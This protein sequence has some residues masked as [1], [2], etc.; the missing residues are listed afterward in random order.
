MDP[1]AGLGKLGNM[2]LWFLVLDIDCHLQCSI[3]A[4]SYGYK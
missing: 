2:S 1:I 4:I 3:H